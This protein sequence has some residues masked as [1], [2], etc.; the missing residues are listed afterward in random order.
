MLLPYSCMFE[1]LT[2]VLTMLRSPFGS[3]LVVCQSHSTPAWIVLCPIFPGTWYWRGL[4][5]TGVAKTYAALTPVQ[6]YRPVQPHNSIRGL[7]YCTMGATCTQT[8]TLLQKLVLLVT[9]VRPDI[10]IYLQGR[11]WNL[12]YTAATLATSQMQCSTTTCTCICLQPT[13][14][15]TTGSQP[16]FSILELA[17]GAHS[18]FGALQVKPLVPACVFELPAAAL[19]NCYSEPELKLATKDCSYPMTDYK[20][21]NLSLY[22][23]LALLCWLGKVW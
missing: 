15:V 2:T 3:G 12:D 6:D 16:T 11:L 14:L 20:L 4:T 5:S 10:A 9:A 1:H 13:K 18:F 19:S 8:H 23:P 7:H 22:L 21:P 17:T